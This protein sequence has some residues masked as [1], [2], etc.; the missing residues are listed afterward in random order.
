[1]QI[2]FPQNRRLTMGLIPVGLAGLALIIFLV[3][4]VWHPWQPPINSPLPTSPEI[5]Q[6]WG[7]RITQVGV[8]ADGG[9]V[10]FRYIVLDPTKA[11]AMIADVE[12]LPVLITEDSKTLVNSAALM[13]PKHD[14]TAGRTY[15]LL[16]RNTH[17]AIQS[18]TP[19]TVKIGDLLL[20]HVIAK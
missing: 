4:R 12:R 11:H 1:M 10:D 19:V 3:A 15:F 9:M 13:D 16:Y 5:E 6:K 20:E 14:L 2:A 17:G 7:I 18:G 8:T